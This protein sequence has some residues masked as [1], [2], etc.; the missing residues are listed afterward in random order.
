MHAIAS[1]S[2]LWQQQRLQLQTR[3]SVPR[4]MDNLCNLWHSLPDEA[5]D[6]AANI[7]G[8]IAVVVADA[9]EAQTFS[10]DELLLPSSNTTYEETFKALLAALRVLSQLFG[11]PLGSSVAKR[12]AMATMLRTRDIAMITT[13]ESHRHAAADTGQSKFNVGEGAA[14][15]PRAVQTCV[16]HIARRLRQDVANQGLVR[17]SAGAVLDALTGVHMQH[18]MPCRVGLNV[19]VLVHYDA[20]VSAL[21]FAIRWLHAMC[22]TT[23]AQCCKLCACCAACARLQVHDE[24]VHAMLDS[25]CAWSARRIRRG[26]MHAISGGAQAAHALQALGALRWQSLATAVIIAAL[27]VVLCRAAVDEDSN[28]QLRGPSAVAVLWALAD[29]RVVPSTTLLLSLQPVLSEWLAQLAESEQLGAAYGGE[30]PLAMETVSAFAL[31]GAF[32]ALR[33]LLPLPL[34]GQL[35]ALLKQVH[36]DAES[37]A[38]AALAI[39]QAAPAAA[40]PALQHALTDVAEQ[41][42][43]ELR[44]GA[45]KQDFVHACAL[46]GCPQVAASLLAPGA[47]PEDE[48]SALMACLQHAEAVHNDDEPLAAV[49][50]CGAQ[51]QRWTGCTDANTL[52][53]SSL[54]DDAANMKSALQQLLQRHSEAE[55]ANVAQA[56]SSPTW[57]VAGV[58]EPA[59]G[60]LPDSAHGRLMPLV[61]SLP[62]VLLMRQGGRQVQHAALLLCPPGATTLSCKVDGLAVPE[63]ALMPPARLAMRCC[64]ML[65]WQCV[66][67]GGEGWQQL[68]TMA[69][70]QAQQPAL[71]QQLQT[72]LSEAAQSG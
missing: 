17:Q 41:H 8:S 7:A 46:A 48:C 34:L 55:A 57:Q 60:A 4:S 42:E 36:G 71:R 35:A 20:A 65:G 22:H 68:Y 54:Q 66:P 45:G 24:E 51:L 39:A 3:R 49:H 28:Q 32:E 1:Q 53:C 38:G 62:S 13:M 50:S 15:V 27:D 31:P 64:R 6:S 58:A 2:V 23:P 70:Q 44:Q 72:L 16:W 29:L 52:H 40:A 61:A 47:F 19:A 12:S 26:H 43:A 21:C 9:L 33:A 25:L 69:Q 11:V 14:E 18:P 10:I 5:A 30:E 59:S 37:T 56:D 67:I 63:A